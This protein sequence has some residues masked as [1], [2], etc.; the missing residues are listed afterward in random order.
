MI[1]AIDAGNTRIKWGLHDGHAWL[2]QGQYA[3]HEIDK[4]E[5]TLDKLATP[6]QIVLSNVAGA[7]LQDQLEHCLRRYAVVLQHVHAQASQC[8]V[9]NAYATPGQLGADRWAALIG[10]HHLGVRTGLVVNA[11]TAI[12]VDALHQGNFLGGIILP[13]YHMMGNLLLQGTA[14]LTNDAGKLSAWPSNTADALETGR[15]LAITGAVTLLREQ[16]ARQSGDMPELVLSGGN[17]A[18]LAIHLS[19]P[20]R[21]VENLVLEG[22]RIIASGE[23]L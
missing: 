19:Q 5:Q 2:S 21:L 7:Q 10:A 15:T 12:T 17:G 20:L 23:C 18:H 22:L 13:G 6:Q 4:F 3:H 11:G 9:R 1:L 14:G 8:G 16:L